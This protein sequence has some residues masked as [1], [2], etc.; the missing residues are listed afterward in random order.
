MTYKPVYDVNQ[1]DLL[2]HGLIEASA[3]TGKTYTIENLV[4]RLLREQDD[5]ELENILIV[6]FTEKAASELKIRIREK[7]EGELDDPG[8]HPETLKKLRVS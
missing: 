6:T 2:Q 3:G 5:V 4:V 1:I 8:H 7:L